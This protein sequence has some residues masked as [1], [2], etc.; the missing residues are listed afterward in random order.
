MTIAAKNAPRGRAAAFAALLAVSAASSGWAQEPETA[1]GEPPAE[2]ASVTAPVV[3]VALDSIIHP[4]AAQL[5][6]E[7][8][9][10]ADEAGAAVLVVELNTPGGLLESTREI[11]KAMLAARTPV[12]VFVG[13]SGAR[14]ASAGFFLLMAA[15]VAAMAPG[16]N[17]GAAHPVAG[18]GKDIEGDL[19]AKVEQDAAATIRSLAA[20]HG[21]NVEL[22][23]AAVVDSRSFT[24]EEALASGLIDLVA[25]TVPELLKALDGRAVTKA[26]AEVRLATADAAV[27]RREMRAFQ[28]FLAVLIHPEIAYLLMTLGFIGLYMEL[29]NPGTVLPGVIGGICLILAFYS[30]SVLP[31]NYAGIALVILAMIFFVAEVY[32]PTFGALTIGGVIALVL[33]AVMLFRDADPAMRIGL[34]VIVGATGTLLVIVVLLLRKALAVRRGKVTTGAEGLVGERGV[35]RTDLDPEGKVFVHGELWRARAETPATAGQS[36]EVTAVS[37]LRLRVRAVEGDVS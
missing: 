25:P 10:Y 29:S 17:T 16:T 11:F 36:V 34:E 22:A 15:D 12:V 13:P 26:G 1:S 7:T 14:A 33:G 28:R 18:Q 20:Q 31:I 35:A 8:L 9:A 6:L 32:T 30:F 5:M 2:P 21:R 37:G 3:H 27:E 23:E 24:A 4:I 19:G